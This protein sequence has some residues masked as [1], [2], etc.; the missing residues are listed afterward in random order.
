MLRTPGSTTHKGL[1]KEQASSRRSVEYKP[2]QK[3]RKK[4]TVTS[5]PAHIKMKTRC[6]SRSDKKL[7]R[8]SQEWWAVLPSKTTPLRLK[9]PICRIINTPLLSLP[10]T[11]F[12]KSLPQSRQVAKS[13]NS[14]STPYPYPTKNCTHSQQHQ[15]KIIHLLQPEEDSRN[16]P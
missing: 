5:Y 9:I 16:Q 15:Q 7:T 14:T 3:V 2:L 8:V 4:E 1:S 6:I 13:C 10:C 11:L 12:N